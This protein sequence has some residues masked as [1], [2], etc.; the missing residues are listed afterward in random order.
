MSKTN[1]ETTQTLENRFERYAHAAAMLRQ[2]IQ[3]AESEDE[4]DYDWKAIDREL[5]DEAM[6]CR[7]PDTDE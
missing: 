2:W 5:K 7:E 6:S 3:E 1:F 4:R